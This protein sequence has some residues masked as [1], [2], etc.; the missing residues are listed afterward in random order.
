MFGQNLINYTH[1]D[2]QEFL[3]KHLIPTDLKAFDEQPVDENGEARPRTDE[4]EEEI[5]RKLK[6]DKRRFTIR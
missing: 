6:A 1:P 3:K 2:D 5:D 4:E